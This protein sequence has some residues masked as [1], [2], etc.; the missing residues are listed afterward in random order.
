MMVVFRVDDM[1]FSHANGDAVD[2]LIS[3]ISKRYR[4]ETE[5]I[6]H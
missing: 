5:L 1:K 4:K 2:A 3:Q 6:I